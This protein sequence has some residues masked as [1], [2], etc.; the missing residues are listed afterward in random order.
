MLLDLSDTHVKILISALLA[1]LH[2]A[3]DEIYWL[4]GD[5]EE[6]K[7]ELAKYK[8]QESEASTNG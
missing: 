1:D 6:L 3:N 4:K 2:K 7:K 5:K 8:P